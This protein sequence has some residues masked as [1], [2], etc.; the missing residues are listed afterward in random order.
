MFPVWEVG[1][2]A[3]EQKEMLSSAVGDVVVPKLLIFLLIIPEK[4]SV[5]MST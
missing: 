3:G 4:V 1:G 5:W 2:G